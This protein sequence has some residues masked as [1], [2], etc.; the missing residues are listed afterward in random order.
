M[1]KKISEL[2]VLTDTLDGT[3][4]I[5]LVKNGGN[6]SVTAK[7]LAANPSYLQ[8]TYVNI[9]SKLTAMNW[10]TANYPITPFNIT[11]LNGK[12][13]ASS[14][15]DPETIYRQKIGDPSTWPTLWVSTLGND[16]NT[17]A[18]EAQ[19][20][21][22]LE[23]AITVANAAGVPHRVMVVWGTYLRTRG[24]TGTSGTTYPT[25]NIAFYAVRGR[26]VVAAA[27]NV[28]YAADGTYSWLYRTTRAGTL[29]VLDLLQK[30]RFGDYI[31][32]LK[33]ADAAACSRVPNSWAQVGNDILIHRADGVAATT[34]NTRCFM[35]IDNF[36]QEGS[37]QSS[38]LFAGAEAGSGFDFEGGRRGCFRSVI[39]GAPVG[40]RGVLAFKD[41]T[42]KYSGGVGAS[43]NIDNFVI[44]SFHGLVVASGCTFN[45]SSKDGF[46]IHNNYNPTTNAKVYCLTINCT[47]ND[48]GRGTSDSN[49]AWTLH[50]TNVWAI[51]IC[52]N[53]S[54]SWGSTFH[55]VHDSKALAV[56]TTCSDSYGDIARGG[57]TEPSE[58]RV[59]N[60]ST[61]WL[62]SCISK[63]FSPMNNAAR[64][65]ETA[66]IY[67]ENTLML[68]TL[69]TPG[70]TGSIIKV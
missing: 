14:T 40:A 67:Y 30:N 9:A 41:C 17:G 5:P 6:V 49:N 64:A 58:F 55:I 52:G 29:R 18:S 12:L 25:V 35:T 1:S 37:T 70:G 8:T 54:T 38:F 4:M 68:G 21:G 57:T 60:T 20:F 26:V 7:K 51:D 53:Y 2:P 48:N 3:E 22:T 15:P 39:Y 19:A 34:A 27:D 45:A 42:F 50:D 66:T 11:S 31:E 16:T 13:L 47:G 61:M 28:T 62:V 56:G 10:D 69:R 46:N 32:L 36:S 23:K 44:D 63:P 24:F 65:D 59:G 43:Q 33:V